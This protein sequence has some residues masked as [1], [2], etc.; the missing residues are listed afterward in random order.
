MLSKLGTHK[1]FKICRNSKI[2]ISQRVVWIWS[3]I[4]QGLECSRHPVCMNSGN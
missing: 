3:E 4:T 2:I 1:C